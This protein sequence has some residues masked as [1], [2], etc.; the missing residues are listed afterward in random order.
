MN[1]HCPHEY[2]DATLRVRYSETDQM[3]RAYYAN[4]LVW[5]EVGRAEYCRVRGFAYSEMERETDT[6]LPVAEAS[7]RYLRPL[8]YDM[9][10]VIRTQVKELR[11]RTVSFAYELR[12]PDGTVVFARGETKHVF[13]TSKGRPKSL[14]ERFFRILYGAA[15]ID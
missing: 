13:T 5:F 14:P 6:F 4:Y 3:A 11:K 9:E 7:C 8:E 1:N 10:F 15:G 12:T 2:V